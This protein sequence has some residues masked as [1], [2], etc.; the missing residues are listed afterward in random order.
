M[1]AI[2]STSMRW[3]IVGINLYLCTI[4]THWGRVTNIC[5]SELTIIW[6]DNGLSPGLHQAIIWTN[7]GI[8]VIRTLGTNFSEILSEI[9]AFSFK[10]MHLKMT[11][12]KWHPFC[13][14]PDVLKIWRPD[15]TIHFLERGHVWY[16]FL[17]AHMTKTSTGPTTRW[18]TMCDSLPE[19]MTSRLLKL[20]VKVI[21][22]L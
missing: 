4:F 6:S 13:L 8:L 5:V 15:Y 18:C 16:L 10:K 17:W 11:S 3:N 9:R 14:G 7:A 12:A 21:S 1:S 22:A 2:I 20:C 19:S